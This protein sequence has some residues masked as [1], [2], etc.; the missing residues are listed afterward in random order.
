MKKKNCLVLPSPRNL[1]KKKKGERVEEQIF[2]ATT[3]ER[4]A[5]YAGN[6]APNKLQEFLFNLHFSAQCDHLH[7]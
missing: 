2:A 7:T 6:S 3:M 5:L 1:K 4:E